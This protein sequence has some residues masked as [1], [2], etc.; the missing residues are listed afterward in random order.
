MNGHEYTDHHAEAVDWLDAVP[1]ELGEA[2][3][4]LAYQIRL[5]DRG[6]GSAKVEDLTDVP[7]AV[8]DE[9]DLALAT[10]ARNGWIERGA[11]RVRMT[12]PALPEVLDADAFH[13]EVAEYLGDSEVPDV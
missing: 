3:V 6:D 4:E 11:E 1:R 2:A 7:I 8:G 12:W 10:L 9:V 5:H 13:R